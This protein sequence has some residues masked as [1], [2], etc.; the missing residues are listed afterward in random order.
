MLR[1]RDNFFGLGLGL[2]VIGLGLGVGLMKY[3]SRSHTLWSRGLKSILYSSSVMTLLTVSRVMLILISGHYEYLTIR[4]S[5]SS[6]II[7][8]LLF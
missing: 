7:H 6:S 5:S 2:T 8:C 4:K 1:S 3:W